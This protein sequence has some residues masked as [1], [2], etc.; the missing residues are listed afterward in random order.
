MPDT[1]P[2]ADAFMRRIL[3][4]PTDPVPRLVFADWLEETGTS[5][6]IAWA[7]YLRLAEERAAAAD[8]DPRRPKLTA[9]LNRLAGSIRAKLIFRAET[10]TEFPDAM[11]RVLPPRNLVVNVDTVMVKPSVAELLPESVAREHRLVPLGVLADR[12]PILAGV[13]PTRPSV[14]TPLAFILGREPVVVRMKE[15]GVDSC[16]DRNYGA[17][18]TEAAVCVHSNWAPTDGL[19]H[20]PPELVGTPAVGF[21]SHLLLNGFLYVA[22]ALEFEA[23]GSHFAVWIWRNGVR[24]RFD[25]VM[26]QSAIVPLLVPA[27]RAHLRDP[28]TNGGITRGDVTLVWWDEP[29]T[30]PVRIEDRSTG[31]HVHVTIPRWGTGAAAALNQAA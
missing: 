14:A 19:R 1:D 8:D 10:L 30:L 3:G 15:G 7:R 12:T 27:L 13:E 22:Q 4:D 6:N 21:L 26:P 11:L 17:A 16:L 20:T 2:N 23:D 5:S 31:H 9:M 28:N 29:Y 24:E 25:E 18:E